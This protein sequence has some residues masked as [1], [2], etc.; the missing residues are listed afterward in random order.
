MSGFTINPMVSRVTAPS[1]GAS[2]GPPS[3]TGDVA[4]RPCTV[5]RHSDTPL[6]IVIPSASVN[7]AVRSGVSRRARQVLSGSTV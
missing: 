3:T 4:L 5:N 2:S 1:S 7:S 6:V